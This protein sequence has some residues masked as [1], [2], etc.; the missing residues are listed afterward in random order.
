MIPLYPSLSGIWDPAHLEVLR[1]FF[2]EGGMSFPCSVVCGG[3]GN[4][5]VTISLDPG[6]AKR[7]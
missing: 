6:L 1:K 7:S 2:I 3:G 5:A 4:N